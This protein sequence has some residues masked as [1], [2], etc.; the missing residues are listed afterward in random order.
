MY[1]N[2]T[3]IEAVRNHCKSGN[4]LGPLPDDTTENI[5]SNSPTDYTPSTLGKWVEKTYSP[6]VQPKDYA[7]PASEPEESAQRPNKR[8]RFVTETRSLKFIPFTADGSDEEA[9]SNPNAGSDDEGQVPAHLQVVAPV[10]EAEKLEIQALRVELNRKSEFWEAERRQWEGEIARLAVERVRWEMKVR[11]ADEIKVSWDADQVAIQQK[12]QQCMKECEK[13]RLQLSEVLIQRD[14]WSV[15]RNAM[16]KERS[17]MA[18]NMIKLN[19]SLKTALESHIQAVDGCINEWNTPILPEEKTSMK[20]SLETHY[21]PLNTF[22]S[23]WIRHESGKT[24]YAEEEDSGQN[25]KGGAGD[26]VLGANVEPIVMK[27]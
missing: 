4:C 23:V 12:Y 2:N 26:R 14:Q 16:V 18:S 3:G 25:G 27:T 11:A 9:V 19:S 10:M 15:A 13:L 22:E 1:S 24:E 20:Y 7:Y 17:A 5:Y 6:T 21:Y 8:R